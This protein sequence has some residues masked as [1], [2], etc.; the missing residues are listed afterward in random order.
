ML[1][2]LTTA[3]LSILVLAG[4][5][6]GEPAE[7]PQPTGTAAAAVTLAP[8]VTIAETRAGTAAQWVLDQLAA[9]D[10]PDAAE[11]EE[12]FDDTFLSQVPAGDVAAVFD[13]LRAVGPYV[14]E[15]YA[16]TEDTAQLPLDGPQDRFVLHINT[17]PDGRVSGLFFAAAEPVPDISSLDDLDA[18]LDALPAQTSLLVAEVEGDTCRALHA[19]DAGEVRPI[20]SIIKLYVLD[21]VRHAVADGEL[22]WQDP[23]TLTD[24][25]RS[26]PSGTLQNE[27]TGTEVSVEEAAAAMIAISDNT[28][29]DLLIDAVGR[30]AVQEAVERLGHHDPSLMEPLITTREMFQ[31]GFTDEALREEW[32]AAGAEERQALVDALPGGEVVVDEALATDVVWTED[33]DWFATAED[34]C[35]AHVGLQAQD[36]ERETVRDILSAN[37]GIDVPEGWS[38]VAFKGG[39]STGEMAGSWL[40]EDDGRRV[41][42]VVQIAG[43]DITMVPDA[44]WMVDVVGQAAAV[45]VEGSE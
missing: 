21:A 25:L 35:R 9:T 7:E 3:V 45:L 11:A 4:C 26:L 37:P 8:G 32:A 28:A 38:Y 36:A 5:A 17:L 43:N 12:R 16:G 40:L 1:R 33:L 6:G 22:D 27:P 2:R 34:L 30:P 20:G 23:L 39:S 24:D 10:G 19:R 42:I 41:V 29:T 14:V 31:L 15:E 13:Q 44:G 18:A